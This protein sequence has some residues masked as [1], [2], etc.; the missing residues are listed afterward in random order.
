MSERN[1]GPY[2]IITIGVTSVP[3]LS[4]PR[5]YSDHGGLP[6]S[7]PIQRTHPM[8]R[9]MIG[10]QR[11][12]IV[13]NLAADNSSPNNEAASS[14]ETRPWSTPHRTQICALGPFP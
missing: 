1:F 6:A 2:A 10:P 8:E 11:R 4:N 12:E 9:V 7:K 14:F 3:R 5:T 13:L